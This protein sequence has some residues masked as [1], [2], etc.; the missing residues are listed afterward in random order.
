MA[1]CCLFFSLP[2]FV[3]QVIKELKDDDIA[4]DHG[5]DA[6]LAVVHV[7]RTLGGLIFAAICQLRPSAAD[8]NKKQQVS[9]DVSHLH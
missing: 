6:L 2:P 5:P 3:L 8:E 4:T 9:L 7:N 1:F